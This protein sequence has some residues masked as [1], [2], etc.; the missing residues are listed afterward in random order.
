MPAIIFTA[1]SGTDQLTMVGHGLL[2]GDGPAAGRNIGGGLP[3]PLVGVTDYWIIRIDD[4]HVKLATSSSN[5]MA[6]TAI[7]LTTN[8]TGTN[9]LEIGIPYRRPRTYAPNSQLSSADLNA[10]FDA[11]PAL[12]ALLT[13]QAQSIWNG[14]QLAGSLRV[15]TDF[16]VGG[17]VTSDLS[18]ATGKKLKHGTKT[19]IVPVLPPT[20]PGPAVGRSAI[21]SNTGSG[22]STLHVDLPLEVGW[23]V[24]TIRMRLTDNATGPATAR[25]RLQSRTESSYTTLHATSNTSNGSG[26]AQ[27]IQA[28]GLAILTAAGTQYTVIA[29]CVTGTT[30]V[31]VHRLE[32]DYA[33]L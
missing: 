19:L 17:M 16:A 8:G 15:D 33:Q 12:H 9:I 25:F 27:T 13:A 31:S 14:I 1:D 28:T 18:L 26:V 20:D 3:S 10:N 23:T 7:N 2:T 6:G 22:A 21:I 5:A 29:D 32:V 24:S 4:D 30:N 11:W